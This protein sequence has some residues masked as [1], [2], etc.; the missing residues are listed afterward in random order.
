MN[1]SVFSVLK[2]IWMT[3]V[4]VVI[5]SPPVVA[6]VYLVYS[7]LLHVAHLPW[8]LWLAALFLIILNAVLLI[9][10]VGVLEMVLLYM[11]ARCIIFVRDL[12]KG[13]HKRSV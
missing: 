6:G 3:L 5:V 7:S 11:V 1:D 4:C 13:F 10:V 2:E 8:L 12:L 9:M